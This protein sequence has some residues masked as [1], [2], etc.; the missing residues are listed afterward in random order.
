MRAGAGKTFVAAALCGW[1]KQ[2]T[3]FITPL[4]HLALQA[5]TDFETMLNAKC[6]INDPSADINIVI[7]NTALTYTASDFAKYSFVIFDEVHLYCS[8]RRRSIFSIA[9]A[10][11]MLGMSATTSDR[12]DKFDKIYYKSLGDPIH[13]HNISGFDFKQLAF[14]LRIKLIKYHGGAEY[15]RTLLH[16]GKP[17]VHLMYKQLMCDR[18][19][20]QIICDEINRFYEDP[21][22][23]IYVFAEECECL[24]N[25][26]DF[27]RE[28]M[29]E[30][31]ADIADIELQDDN[32]IGY[33]VGGLPSADINKIKLN[34][35]IVFTTY[36]L[37]STGTSWTKMNA[38]ILATPRKSGT[39]QLVGRILRQGSD[40][41]I[42]RDIIDIV[43]MNTFLRKQLTA[44]KQC[45]KIY[46][47]KVE[48]VTY[49]YLAY[50]RKYKPVMER[51]AVIEDRPLEVIE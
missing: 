16:A 48:K 30:K 28:Y 29:K 32:Q 37:S 25:I 14:D 21:V 2:R 22:R 13:A 35:R 40:I 12:V 31:N 23:N 9:G 3:L 11:Y 49:K 38:M 47:H 15:T 42:P 5:K 39:T 18:I 50:K 51:A 41:K 17:S 33:F 34:A 19:R 1:L 27:Y 6:G 44:R 8:E 7:I 46:P 45:Y 36:R 43:D 20:M 26:I 4:K 10:P 24:R